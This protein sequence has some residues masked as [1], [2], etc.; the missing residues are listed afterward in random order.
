MNQQVKPDD[1]SVAKRQM[2]L[3]GIP[4]YVY[5]A[6]RAQRHSS[7]RRGIAFRFTLLAWHCWWNTEL[8]AI[9]PDAKRGRR[10]GEYV[11]ARLGDKGD[12]EHGN[13]YAATPQQN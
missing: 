8:T 10:K 3:Y 11:M 4:A 6:W 7:L 12:Y 1:V 9:G 13:V 5:Q 2:E